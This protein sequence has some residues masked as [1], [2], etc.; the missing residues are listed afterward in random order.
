MDM[1]ASKSEDTSKENESTILPQ[2]EQ[3]RRLNEPTDKLYFMRT[4]VV[5]CLGEIE[6]K[7]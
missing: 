1:P 6:F 5:S 2:K 4:P 3:K 7:T